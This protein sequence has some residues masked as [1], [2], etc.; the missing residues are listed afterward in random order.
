[1]RRLVQ[2]LFCN[3][4]QSGLKTSSNLPIVT[5]AEKGT[6]RLWTQVCVAPKALLCTIIFLGLVEILEHSG[7]AEV[8]DLGWHAA[9]RSLTVGVFALGLCF[10]VYSMMPTPRPPPPEAH[11]WQK[12][13]PQD[14]GLLVPWFPIFS[15]H[16][17]TD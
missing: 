10:L 11:Q 9:W 2:N 14:P 3:G 4:S 6:G 5:R 13:L 12:S 17:T 8:R 1:M 16:A 7:R 15:S